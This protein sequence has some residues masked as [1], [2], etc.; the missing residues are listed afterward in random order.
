M[1]YKMMPN[2]VDKT[3]YKVVNNDLQS[4]YQYFSY[5]MGKTYIEE[6]FD[7]NENNSCSKGFYAVDVEG[8]PYAYGDLE[9]EK[10]MK[11]RVEGRAVEINDFKRRYERLTPLGIA[12]MKKEI[13]PKAKEKYENGEVNYRLHAALDPIRP[14][15]RHNNGTRSLIKGSLKDFYKK[16]IG[17]GLHPKDFLPDTY[18]S[19]QVYDMMTELLVDHINKIGKEIDSN[20]D[21]YITHETLDKLIACYVVDLFDHSI[22]GKDKV[23]SG[24]SLLQNG[25][26]PADNKD[27]LSCIDISKPTEND[28]Y[29]FDTDPTLIRSDTLDWVGSDGN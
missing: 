11:V 9:N 1:F 8:L 12:S 3:L 16:W 25:I 17:T 18:T 19:T 10:I 23:S 27:K 5:E 24:L 13:K 14:W 22:K 2:R 7:T 21:L 20:K 4:V 28:T 26:I 29:I 6:N 15:E